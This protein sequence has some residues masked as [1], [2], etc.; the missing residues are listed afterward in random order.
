MALFRIRPQEL[1]KQT[2]APAD[3]ILATRGGGKRH[4]STIRYSSLNSLRVMDCGRATS[5]TRI[6]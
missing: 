3:L 6:R 1:S 2:D 4:A 5:R